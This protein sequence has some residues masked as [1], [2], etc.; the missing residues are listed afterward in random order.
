MSPN[1]RQGNAMTST[2]SLPLQHVYPMPTSD[3]SRFDVGSEAPNGSTN[4]PAMSSRPEAIPLQHPR[5]MIPVSPAIYSGQMVYDHSY[6]APAG[7]SVFPQAQ[8]HRHPGVSDVRSSI[9]EA[10]LP[11]NPP[12]FEQQVDDTVQDF[13]IRRRDTSPARF[14]VDAVSSS[15]APRRRSS[16]KD[17]TSA[18]RFDLTE[19]QEERERRE[20]RRKREQDKER[21]QA[22]K[23]DETERERRAAKEGSFEERG[24]KAKPEKGLERP[25]K[26]WVAPTVAGVVGAA[27]TSA[28]V[29]ERSKSEETREERRERRRRERELEDEEDA[30]KKSE[31]RRRQRERADQEIATHESERLPDE[32]SAPNLDQQERS[33]KRRDMSVWQEA[34]STKRGSSHENYGAF[35]TPLELLNKSSDQAKVSSANADADI[36]LEQVPHIVTVEP[37]RT[38][39]LSDSPTFSLADIDDKVDSSRQSFTWQVPRLRLVEPT[40]PS[41]RGSTPLLQPKDACDE[42]FEEPRKDGSPSKVKWADDENREYTIIAPKEDRDEFIE[43]VSGGIIDPDLVDLSAKMHEHQLPD[44]EAHQYRDSA[45]ESNSAS[46]GEDV[47]FAATL[48]ASA[49]DAGFDPSIVTNNPTYRRRDSP[50]GSKERSMPGAFDD[51]DEPRLKKRQRKRKEKNSRRQSQNDGPDGRDDDKIVQNIISQVEESESQASDKVPSESLEDEW[52]SINLDEYKK[53]EKR[54]GFESGDDSVETSDF[55]NKTSES[56]TDDVY[57]SPSEDVRSISSTSNEAASDSKSREEWKGANSGFDDAASTLIFP[58]T[59][60]SNGSPKTI[61]KGKRKGN[62]WDLFLSKST[63]NT[64]QDNSSNVATDEAGLEAFHESEK[65]NEMP[66][67][68]KPTDGRDGS[69]DSKEENSTGSTTPQ[70]LDR[71]SKTFP[72]QVC[73]PLPNHAPSQRSLIS[74]QDQ[75]TSLP[76]T[77]LNAG[78]V[79]KYLDHGVELEQVEEKQPESFLG[80]RPEPPPPPDTGGVKEQIF[81]SLQTTSLPTS[82]RAGLDTKNRRFSD[83]EI[84]DKTQTTSAL[85]SSPTAVPFHFRQPGRPSSTVRSLSQT[86]LLSNR[87]SADLAP[88]QKIRPRDEVYPS[89]PSSHTTSRSSSVAASEE[90]ER[91]QEGVYEWKETR[92]KPIEVEHAPVVSHLMQPHLLDSLQAT[93]TA[94]SLHH[95]KTALDMPSPQAPRD[96]SPKVIIEDDPPDSNPTS[97]KGA[98]GSILGGSATVAKNET[99]EK[100]FPSTESLPQE[101]DEDLGRDLD[102]TGLDTVTN[103][104]RD[105]SPYQEDFSAQKSKKGKKSKRKAGQFRQGTVQPSLTEAAKAKPSMEAI[106]PDPLSPDEM[107]QI[108]EQDV[109]DAVDSWSPSVRSSAKFKR[110]KKGKIRMPVEQLPA[111][112]R[113]F[114][115]AHEPPWNNLETVASAKDQQN[116]SL[117]REISRKQVVDVMTVTPQDADKG[118]VEASQPATVVVQA[119]AKILAEQNRTEPNGQMGNKGYMDLSQDDREP[120]DVEE[121]DLP[122]DNFQT[123]TPPEDIPQDDLQT[124]TLP[125]AHI[126]Q[127]TFTQNELPQHNLRRG[128]VPQFE[129]QQKIQLQDDTL[130]LTFPQEDFSQPQSQEALSVQGDLHS[131]NLLP[132]SSIS[133]PATA[134]FEDSFLGK[135]H[136]GQSESP[137]I[138]PSSK[139]HSRGN[140]TTVV[141]LELEFSPR[142]TPLPDSDDEYELLDGGLQTPILA[143]LHGHDDEE[144]GV[145]ELNPLDTS[146]LHDSFALQ[147]QLQDLPS[148]ANQN[149]AAEDFAVPSKEIS[150]MG[151]KAQQSFSGA[152]NRTTELQGK[153]EPSPNV[154]TSTTLEDDSIK[155]LSAEPAAETPQGKSEN[156]E[157]EFGSFTN[158]AGGDIGKEA[159]Q[160]SS[161]EN[162]NTIEMHERQE[163]IPQVATLGALEDHET[164]KLL[165]ESAVN[166]FFQPK[167]EP[168]KDEWTGINERKQITNGEEFKPNFSVANIKTTSIEEEKESLS[169]FATLEEPEYRKALDLTGEPTMHVPESE[170]VE[171][172]P[173]TLVNEFSNKAKKSKM[174]EDERPGFDSNTDKSAQN[175]GSKTVR[176]GPGQEEAELQFEQQSDARDDLNASPSSFDIKR[177][178][179]VSAELGSSKIENFVADESKESFPSNS[180][181]E[182]TLR[183]SL[184]DQAIGCDERKMPGSFEPDNLKLEN[185][186]GK[187]H[188]GAKSP[189]LDPLVSSTNAAEVVQE[190]LAGKNNPEPATDTQSE[191]MA[192]STSMKHVTADSPMEK[193]EV[194]WDTLKKKKKGKKG[195]KTEAIS[196]EEPEN[197][198]SADVSSQTREVST[199]L[200][201]EPAMDRIVEEDEQD[202]E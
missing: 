98:L 34:A 66:K 124:K 61:P 52:K 18:V 8:N 170:L 54:K 143:P 73:I 196:W 189:T 76:S 38:H 125:P 174:H 142:L 186:I 13:K 127:V 32:I 118:E 194:L 188:D 147:G 138:N 181:A 192:I 141:P 202:R 103:P 101:E 104:S 151:K 41:T 71:L 30:L 160:N 195:K 82:P 14:E 21:R 49:E 117:T 198:Q 150:E 5:P 183:K 11:G 7:V 129:G 116:D 179:Q 40:P 9:H 4:R 173:Q 25:E 95:S 2:S 140:P 79:A 130:R 59:T 27:I 197:L 132:L 60:E 133:A 156:L 115:N 180:Q 162:S 72:V 100:H 159:Y 102:D 37:K 89:L 68:R 154:T 145:V 167:I 165:D 171:K 123:S 108:E 172:V 158:S 137:G 56:K 201:H 177:A 134:N 131:G 176:P 26:S 31:R 42:D 139:E 6:S 65:R 157:D 166:D 109:Q 112:A 164:L 146:H 178:P 169:P 99:I 28:A 84:C 81:T 187:A 69:H 19:E 44:A 106:N 191:A 77:S 161:A 74:S 126:P 168:L 36:D 17:D 163:M 10:S 175:Q 53:S 148:E 50:P 70:V 16:A 107:R 67:E 155:A 57:K 182:H 22:E 39:D 97:N 51:V 128:R 87:A 91:R 23:Q 63:D 24:S 153:D 113:S 190:T 12:R 75:E 80:M 193:D 47:E 110:G 120:D 43:P 92:H 199:Q 119:P 83:A 20:R 149:D 64:P 33:I 62:L 121:D 94:S 3:P 144:K 29:A 184:E 105:D 88:K 85:P 15:I 136:A 58:S 185:A 90:R 48:A 45:M 93:P 35:F 46:Y 55:A 200:E 135:G 86:P 78:S 122:Q 152:D 1:Q 111:E 114:S 96:L